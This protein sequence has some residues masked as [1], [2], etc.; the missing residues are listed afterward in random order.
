MT[1]KAELLKV[2]RLQC[3]ECMGSESARKG[4]F[5]QT[6]RNLVVDCTA[7]KCSLFPF[8]L[9]KDPWPTRKGNPDALKKARFHRSV[10]SDS[11]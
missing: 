7:P 6:A 1:T 5:D 3:E 9:G 8:R 11:S 2:I 4:E 10:A